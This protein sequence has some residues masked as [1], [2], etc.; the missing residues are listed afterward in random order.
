M[1]CQLNCYY[2]YNLRVNVKDNSRI[3]LAFDY[4]QPRQFPSYFSQMI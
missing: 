4:I 3:I 1:I 2:I